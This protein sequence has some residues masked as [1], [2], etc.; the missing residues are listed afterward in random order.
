MEQAD[1]VT[2]RILLE[3]GAKPDFNSNDSSV[4]NGQYGGECMLGM[5]DELVPPLIAAVSRG[6]EALVRLLVKHGADVN[7]A[8]HRGIGSK[9]K[10]VPDGFMG[11]PLLLAMQ[12]GFEEIAALLRENGGREEAGTW[13]EVFQKHFSDWE[14]K[15]PGLG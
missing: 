7:V 9:E 10:N 14:Y 11:A 13:D 6:N 1:G 5:T 4:L 8:Y 12:L 15:R 2:A 3:N